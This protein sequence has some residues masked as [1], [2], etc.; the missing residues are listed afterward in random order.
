MGPAEKRFLFLYSK[1]NPKLPTIAPESLKNASKTRK[2]PMKPHPAKGGLQTPLKAF[3][4]K[5]KTSSDTSRA[6]SIH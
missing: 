6:E 4:I 3:L 5:C 2:Q 1:P